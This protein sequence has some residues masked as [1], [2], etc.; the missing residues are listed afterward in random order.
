MKEARYFFVPEADKNDALPE[1]E[2]LH[3]I[4]VLRLTEG[5]EIFLID[6]VGHF[7]RAVISC[8]TSKKCFYEIKQSMLQTP[9]W[10]GLIHLA[11]APT[12]NMDRMEWMAEKATEIGCNEL[13]FVN[14]RFSERRV[15]KTN[16]IEKIVVAAVKQ[17]RKAWKPVVNDMVDF[18][19]F[20]LNHTK[21]LRFIAHCY[22]EIEKVDFFQKLMAT[23]TPPDEDIT[24]LIGP[25]GDFS[26]D[27][28]KWAVS[29][30]FQSISLGE[31]RLRTETACLFALAA[32][33]LARRII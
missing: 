9:L 4:R 16:R 5:D 20:V 31:C 14:C 7:H 8:A 15:V 19:E 24:I 3:A 28:V 10:H 30:G 26:V 29:Q 13:S 11:V 33:Q 6:G 12:K 18:Q 22:D 2:A 1:E 21:G 25:E 32:A 27:E 23:D 17:S